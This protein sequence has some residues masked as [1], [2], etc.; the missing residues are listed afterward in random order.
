MLESLDGFIIVF[1][2]R[3]A[4]FY[5]SDSITAQLGYLPVSSIAFRI[6]FLCVVCFVNLLTI[7][8]RF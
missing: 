3:G 1:S 4:I 5:A 7:D 6:L 2:S 8:Q